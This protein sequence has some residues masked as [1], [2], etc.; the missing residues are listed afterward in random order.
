M[1]ADITWETITL[2]VATAWN[3]AVILGD[4]GF[5]DLQH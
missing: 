3:P 2:G 5:E 4:V 1:F